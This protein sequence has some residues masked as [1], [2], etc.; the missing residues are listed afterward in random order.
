VQEKQWKYDEKRKAADSY[1]DVSKTNTIFVQLF[2]SCEHK[3]TDNKQQ[4][5]IIIISGFS[6]QTDE[7]I[8]QRINSPCNSRR[9]RRRGAWTLLSL[10]W[11]NQHLHGYLHHL[12]E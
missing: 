1:V 3:S 4:Q 11:V 2:F 9:R 10:P 5:I 8:H 7:Q 12:L 6:T